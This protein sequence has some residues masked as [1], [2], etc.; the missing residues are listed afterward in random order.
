MEKSREVL[1]SILS[2]LREDYEVSDMRTCGYWTAVTSNRCGLASSMATSLP[3]LETN[4]VQEAGNLFPTGAKV[5]AQ[6]CLSPH[7]LEASIGIAALNSALPMDESLFD[8]LNAEAEIRL[9]GEKKRIAVIGH[10]STPFTGPAVFP[11]FPPQKSSRGVWP[12]PRHGPY[13]W[14]SACAGQH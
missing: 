7:M 2:K 6:L 13:R 1:Q 4:Q 12:A 10:F 11:A 8:D 9:R 14:H 5:L 3:P